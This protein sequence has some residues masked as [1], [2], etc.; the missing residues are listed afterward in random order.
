MP[1]GKGYKR[2][3]SAQRAQQGDLR[4]V[5]GAAGV[6]ENPPVI[7]K[8]AGSGAE[9]AAR[10]TGRKGDG[11]NNIKYGTSGERGHDGVMGPRGGTRT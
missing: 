7:T 10:K 6:G 4:R 2:G 11:N 5:P 3:L 1:K 9:P 8:Q